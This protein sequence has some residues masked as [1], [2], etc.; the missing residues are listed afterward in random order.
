[1]QPVHAAIAQGFDYTDFVATPDHRDQVLAM[2]GE[3]PGQLQR[4][5]II[6]LA[7]H[8]QREAL[9]RAQSRLPNVTV[10]PF[11]DLLERTFRRFE[12]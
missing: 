2:F 5:V 7:Q 11:N 3:E 10:T 4:E 1:M 9:A 6:G 12:S 8:E